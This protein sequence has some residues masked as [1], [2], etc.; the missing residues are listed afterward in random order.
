MKRPHILALTGMTLIVLGLIVLMTPIMAQDED[1]GASVPAP[2]EILVDYY[3]IWVESPHADITAEAFNHWNEDDPQ[4]VPA[5]CATCH[6]PDGYQDFIGADGSEAG[7]VDMAHPIGSVVTCN[8]CH[9]QTTA[10]LTSVTFPSGVEITD[11]GDDSRCMICH[12][13]RASSVT[14]MNSLAE[15]GVEDMN[16]VNEDLGFINIHYYAAAASLYGSEV[17]AGYEF[18]GLRY[19]MRNDHVDG[20]DTCIDCHDPHSLEVNVTSCATCHE[21]VRDAEDLPDIRMNGSLIDYDG[22]GDIEEGIKGELDTLR[23]MLYTAIQTYAEEV[24]EACQLSMILM[25]IPTSLTIWMAMVK[26]VK[27]KPILAIATPRL[28]VTFKLQPTTIRFH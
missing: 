15:A 9:N 1:V 28:Q 18:E 11:L 6:S 27:T 3:N 24:I 10:S 4:E 23:E 2:P 14:V 5:S 13:G 26:P 8:A 25:P 16:A 12:Q 7:V 22:D 20:Y 21:D 17:H 19:Q